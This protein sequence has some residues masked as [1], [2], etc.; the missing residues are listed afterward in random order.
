MGVVVPYVLPTIIP[1]GTIDYFAMTALP[2]GWLK[3]NGAAVSR[4]TYAGLYIAIGTTFGAGD[5]ATTFNLPDL[6]GEFVRGWADDRAVDTGRGIGT[7]QADD[8]I[9][10]THTYTGDTSLA[11]G[12][13]GGGSNGWSQPG[14]ISGATGGAETRPRNVAMMACIKAW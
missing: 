7:A 6:R 2:N 14:M 4:A 3:A 13:A 10:H 9:S 11:Y 12:A 5:G 1:P 8:I